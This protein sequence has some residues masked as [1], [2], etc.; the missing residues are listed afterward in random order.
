MLLDKNPAELHAPVLRDRCVELLAPALSEAGSVFVDGTLGMGGHSEAVLEACPNAKLV[1][2]DRDR[3]AISLA[4]R[5]LERFGDRVNLI[6][7]VY[8]ELDERL[9]E[10][11]IDEIHGALFDL[12]VSS[13]QLDEAERG[14]SYARNAPLDMRMDQSG[15]ETAAEL[16]AR[17]CEAEL[18]DLFYRYGDEKLAPRYAS[19]ICKAR[20]LAPITTTGQLVEILQQA[21]PAARRDAGHP[22]KRVFQALRI[23]V[24]GELEALESAIPQALDRL[25]NGGRIVIESYQSLEDRFVK[26]ELQ[27][28][29]TSSAPR[30]LPMELPEH[31]PEF[32]LLVRGA[33][34][35]SDEE[36]ERNPRAIPVRLRAAERIRRH[37]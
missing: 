12:G 31:Q 20:D 7:A 17:L 23:A 34:R 8:D 37:A 26:R 2:F 18:R 19:H 29:S 24:N 13:L 6:H 9:D 25:A 14:F 16:I 21:T 33:E 28:R 11:G 27:R 1:A 10:L 30:E 36:A 22:A 5:R 4:A 35:A 15:G 32:A 3:D